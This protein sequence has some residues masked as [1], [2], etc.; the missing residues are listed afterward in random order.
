MGERTSY[1]PGTFSWVDL[2]TT[3]IEGA[4]RFYGQL[5]GW[6][7][8]D[9]PAGE[10]HTYTMLSLDGK[11]VGGGMQLGE[12]QAS[13]GVPPHWNSYVTVEDIDA[14]AKRV[15][16]LGGN[17]IVE[18]MDATEAGRMAVAADPT[19]AAFSMWQPK[20]HPGAALVNAPGALAWNELGTSDVE[21]AKEFYS[22][23][24]GWSAQELGD[25]AYTVVQVGDRGNGGIRAQSEQEAGV[26]PSWLVYF[27]ADDADASA[28]KASD[29]G[30][31]V[32]LPPSDIPVAGEGARF[33]VLAD[34]QGAVFALY[35]GNLQD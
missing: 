28:A 9:M 10:G 29:L 33:A 3:D 20:Q 22:A 14:A 26:P 34:P 24:F 2:A 4:K 18:P 30:A 16:E 23:L 27:A 12:E 1:P 5:F 11:A 21:K 15:A 31:S 32:V 8:E 35:S 17:V 19:G 13:Q 6:S 25:G 7:A